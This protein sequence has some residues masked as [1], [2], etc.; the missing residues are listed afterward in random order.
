MFKNNP[1]KKDE[2]YEELIK[3]DDFLKKIIQLIM[4]T[5]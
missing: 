2:L 3:L 5:I 1:L 4:L